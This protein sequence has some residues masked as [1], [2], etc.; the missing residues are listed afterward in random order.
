MLVSGGQILAIDRVYTDKYTISGDGVQH[1]LGVKTEVIATTALVSDTSAKLQSEI[2]T[3][4]G[5]FNYYYPTSATSGAQQ[6]EEAF[7]KFKTT[8]TIVSA[9]KNVGVHSAYNEAGAIVYTVSADDVVQREIKIIG[10][11]G[12]SAKYDNAASAWN[13]GVSA[14]YVTTDKLDDYYS[15]NTVDGMFDNTSAW[16]KDTFLSASVIDNYY[17]KSATSGKDEIQ[18]ALD[19]KQNKTDMSAYALSA[20]VDEH[21]QP[22]GDYVTPEELETALEPYAQTDWVTEQ[23]N[24]KVDTSA[25]SAYAQSA[26]V[27]EH[28]QTKGKYVT[29]ADDSL[30]GKQLVLKDNTW[31]E[32]EETDWTDKIAEASAAAVQSAVNTVKGKFDLTEDETISGYDGVPFYHQSLEDY[33]TK[34]Y[35]DNQVEEVSSWAD[36]TFLKKGN[37]L[38][39]DALNDVSGKWNDAYNIVNE[40]SAYWN[41]VSAFSANSGRFLTAEGVTDPGLAYFLKKD[42]ETDEVTW[43]GV[44]LSNLGKMYGISS[45]SDNVYVGIS[46]D[47]ETN[48]PFYVVSASSASTVVLPDISGNGVSAW[49]DDE[50]NK[51]FVSANIVGNHGVSAKYDANSN[52]WDVGISANNY[53]FLFGHYSNNEVLT[54]GAI[55]KLDSNNYHG[56]EIDEDG[57]ITLPETTNKFTFC[58][59]EYIDDNISQ[60]HNY[61]LNKLVLSA[62]S[63]DQIVASQNYYPAEV[64]SSNVTLALTIDAAA[65]PNR[66]YCIVYKG[67]DVAVN[68]LHIEA[69]ILEEV[70]SLDSTAGAAQDYTGR[71]PIRV[72]DNSKVVELLYD[73]NVFSLKHD[74]ALQA[75]ILT[76]EGSGGEVVNKETFDKLLNS[77]NGRIVETIPIGAINQKSVLGA[78]KRWAYVFR[79]MI[80]FDMDPTTTARIITGNASA[81]QST[82]IVA[83]YELDEANN[84]IWLKWW[85]APTVLSKA[86]GEHVLSADSG[87]TRTETI[88][89]DR[90]YYV[91]VLCYAQQIEILGET[92][93]LTSDI[94]DWDIAYVDDNMNTAERRNPMTY[95]G[96]DMASSPLGVTAG[97]TLKPYVGFKNVINE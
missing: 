37:Y 53:S 92:N 66:E 29:S 45:L 97:A 56:I 20:W 4:S 21:Y 58:I 49:K 3:V 22:A 64:G 32:L 76:I 12:V 82:V 75:D 26:W 9:G 81:N 87:C 39:A 30:A 95:N 18:T 44:D 90:L 24:A 50:Q 84:Q 61:L 35:V 28:Y 43:S 54:D 96:D 8:Q 31:T 27:D 63:N 86:K 59:N 72:V 62:L 93:D 42:E 38:S 78:D 34:E 19:K 41:E 71:N 73:S 89:P 94:G 69:S 79:P 14:N 7:D 5:K 11:N 52:T 67:S 36:N 85:S 13:V 10:T 48:E 23:L 1:P 25:M 17:P 55:L 83:V 70:T 40:Y 33:A 51:Y 16:A 15:K 77:V 80:Q 2:D 74:E 47:P 46:A 88:Y 68:K 60:D 91:T 6:L 65:A 57:F